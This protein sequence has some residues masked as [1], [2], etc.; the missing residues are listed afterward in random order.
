MQ[1]RTHSLLESMLNTASGF[2]I[3]V[4]IQMVVNWWYALPL[5]FGQSVG[6]ITIFTLASVVRSYF[7][8]RF[9]NRKIV[10]YDNEDDTRL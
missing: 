5:K 1:S 10:C 9:F 2:F 8:R 6:I 4:A 3:A 7:W